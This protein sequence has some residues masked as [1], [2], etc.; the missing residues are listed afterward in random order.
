MISNKL[1]FK[2]YYVL[3]SELILEHFLDQKSFQCQCKGLQQTEKNW[4]FTDNTQC[5]SLIKLTLH[6]H[7]KNY[8]YYEDV[9]S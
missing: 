3:R 8:N 1:I 4:K 5:T 2:S 7:S 9:T 6:S